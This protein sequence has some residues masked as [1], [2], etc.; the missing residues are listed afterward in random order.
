MFLLST[1]MSL[2]N[3]TNKYINN[4]HKNGLELILMKDSPEDIIISFPHMVFA[5]SCTELW[6]QRK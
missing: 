6:T 2:G 1:R 3:A 4:A 5:L